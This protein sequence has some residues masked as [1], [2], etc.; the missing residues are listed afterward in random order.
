MR[1]ANQGW[2]SLEIARATSI[3]LGEVEL[4]LELTPQ[5]K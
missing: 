1:L 5:S 3:S 4:I 2:S